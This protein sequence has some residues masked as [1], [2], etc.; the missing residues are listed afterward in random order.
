MLSTLLILSSFTFEVPRAT[1]EKTYEDSIRSIK[2]ARVEFKA[3]NYPKGCIAAGWA[4]SS[5]AHLHFVMGSTEKTLVNDAD[6]ILNEALAYE[7]L[8][9]LASHVPYNNPIYKKLELESDGAFQKLSSALPRSRFYKSIPI[10]PPS[11]QPIEY[12]YGHLTFPDYSPEKNRLALC[13]AASSLVQELRYHEP[14]FAILDSENVHP[15]LRTA[16]QVVGFC[17]LSQVS[18]QEKSRLYEL[19]DALNSSFVRYY[20]LLRKDL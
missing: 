8:C 11:M 17:H 1:I 10:Y 14:M 9:G 4:A 2:T 6:T 3:G 16:Y 5:A 7:S 20:N 13:Y 15:M 19:L 18:V 12:T